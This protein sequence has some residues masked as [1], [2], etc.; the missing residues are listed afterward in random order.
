M[1]KKQYR[2]EID[3]LRALSVVAVIIY[4]AKINL[5]GIDIAPGGFIG[6]DIFLVIS[7]YLITSI[8]I[9]EINKTSNFSFSNFYERRIRRIIPALLFVMILQ[10]PLA[11]YFLLPQEFIEYSKS[12]IYSLSFVSNYFFYYSGQIYD[13][14]DSLLSPFIH[15]WS[16][17]VE[18]QFYIIFPLIF[19]LSFKIFKNQFFSIILFL[20]ILSFI[21]AEYG[22]RNHPSFAFYS[23]HTRVWELLLGSMMAYLELSR[24]GLKK[25]QNW[26]SKY[27]SNIGLLLIIFS[28]LF[29]NENIFHPSFLT[30]LP[31]MG[32]S[33]II[34]F[35][36]DETISYKIL[37][38][39]PFVFTGLISYSLYLWHYP[40][41]AFSRISNFFEEN[42]FGQIFILIFII[43][44]SVLSYFVIEKPFRNKNVI[45]KK[46]LIF[47]ITVSVLFLIFLSFSV[48]KN[49]GYKSRIQPV[50]FNEY[51]FSDRLKSKD[52]NG[53]CFNRAKN[54]CVKN[55]NGNKTVFLIGDSLM[56]AIS[57]DLEKKVVSLGYRFAPLTYSGCFFILDISTY[58]KKTKKKTKCNEELQ[59]KRLNMILKEK[60]SIIVLGGHIQKYLSEKDVKLV[61]NQYKYGDW[62]STYLISKSDKE[63]RLLTTLSKI[64]KNN[65]IILLYPFPEVGYNLSQ[66]INNIYKKNKNSFR[67]KSLMTIDYKLYT[68]RNKETFEIY[69]KIKN[70]DIIKVYPHKAFCNKEIKNKCVFNELKNI[71]FYD[72]IHPSGYGA[73]MINQ[74]IL[75]KINKLENVNN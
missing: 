32:V 29:Y 37:S 14:T 40:V 15:T 70:P 19:F 25:S 60:N 43:L 23:I 20:F 44:L 1:Y 8:I 12:I 58:N 64:S 66:R 11:W 42:F 53:I 65:I 72:E 2:P 36:N 52:E 24:K 28:F 62:H 38:L 5:F 30:I 4:H 35:S 54:F 61:D 9:K 3:G 59:M 26:F 51:E 68:E 46:M 74:L 39:K 41:F 34:F 50:I 47:I 6:V 45:K 31:L 67:E 73:H 69:D 22:S 71:Y 13:A 55:E 27:S 18:E 7:G 33:F 21:S 57:Y 75:N 49:N 10:F 17:S 16:L 48:I 56:D 63:K